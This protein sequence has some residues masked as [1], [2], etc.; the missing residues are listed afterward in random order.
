MPSIPFD[1]LGSRRPIAMEFC[2]IIARRDPR[3]RLAEV[4]PLSRLPRRM[5]DLIRQNFGLLIAYVL[6]GFVVVSGAAILYPP[7]RDL[8]T[9][10][11]GLADG[12]ESTA[13]VTLATLL[14]GMSV[15][16][17]RWLIVDSFHHWTGLRRPE[18]DDA[19]LPAKLPAFTAIVE[20]HYR[21]Y[22]FH[23]NLAVAIACVYIAWRV[24][25]PPF[26]P[27]A[28]EAFLLIECLFLATSRD[29]LRKYYARASRL[30]GSP[31]SIE[32]SARDVQ[33]QSPAEARRQKV[34]RGQGRRRQEAGKEVEVAP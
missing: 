2:T 29:N 28:D 19:G 20:D 4:R 15:S 22:Q 14:A 16:S 13:F 21:F 24:Q 25:Q 1:M 11:L 6:P 5:N 3:F 26:A 32:R 23:A 10:T 31:Q 33:R 12:V 30:L 8:V 27:W 7:V 9:P 34:F 18:W 17:L